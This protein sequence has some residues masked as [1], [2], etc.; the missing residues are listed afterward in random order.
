LE[1]PSS[2]SQILRLDQRAFFHAFGFL[3]LPGFFDKG[4]FDALVAEGDAA[5]AWVDA[6]RSRRA[7]SERLVRAGHIPAVYVPLVGDL[8]PTSRALAESPRLL[9]LAEELVGMR[10]A[11]KLPKL[12]RYDGD[13]RWHADAPAGLR[14]VKLA[15]YFEQLTAGN[16]ALRVAPGSQHPRASALV[17]DYVRSADPA[18]LPAHFLETRPGDL[19]LF[20][21][22]LWHASFG[23]R[24]RRQ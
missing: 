3:R 23:G 5:L 4:R 1:G 12:V 16:G 13:S 21:V 22:G 19:I 24:Y 20:D 15:A 18:T 14:G 7:M 6:A 17:G 8:A 10:C 11:P 2:Y 9:H